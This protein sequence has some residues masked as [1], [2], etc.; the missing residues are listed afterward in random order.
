MYARERDGKV[1]VPS[2]T[3]VLGVYDSEMG[4][5]DALCAA[6]A[7][8]EDATAIA[9]AVSLA[10]NPKEAA[11][12]VRGFVD[13]HK[14]AAERD[15]D[16]AAVRGDFVHNYAEAYALRLMDR[17]P[18]AEVNEHLELCRE[19]GLQKY[20]DSFHAFWSKF[21][22][23][24]L[25]PEATV[26][27]STVGYA[28]T[29]DL[30]CKINGIDVIVDWKTKKKIFEYQHYSDPEPRRTKPKALQ[31]IVAMQLA[32]AANAEE[33]WI[34][35]ETPAEDRWEEW[36]FRPALGIAVGIGPDTYVARP[37][38]IWNPRVF[39]SFTSLAAAWN[40]RW[41]QERVMGPD[42]TGPEQVTALLT[43]SRM[44]ELKAA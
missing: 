24:P 40:W 36:T 5:W 42:L 43:P 18:L 35:G 13:V 32:A 9:E 2:I 10:R 16:L 4:W 17:V 38:D 1:K 22:P 21:Q 34:P 7:S 30:T 12:I 26:W 39:A 19:Q 33:L 14:D 25:L 11:R 27:N 8:A 31:P 20:V 44:P 28:G 37:F 23:I 29:T 41:V 3:T 15:R 6:R